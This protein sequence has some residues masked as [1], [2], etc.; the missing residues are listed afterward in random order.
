LKDNH[1]KA[2]K[3]DIN[4][5]GQNSNKDNKAVTKVNNNKPPKEGEAVKS[6]QKE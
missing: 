3:L 2:L 6:R 1:S 5:V 4:Q